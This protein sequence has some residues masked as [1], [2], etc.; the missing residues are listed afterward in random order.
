MLH[1][2]S[3]A[4]SELYLT[5][6]ELADKYLN[7][8]TGVG[9]V[10]SN[11]TYIHLWKFR[12]TRINTRVRGRT[13]LRHQYLSLDETVCLSLV[14]IPCQPD[15]GIGTRTIYTQKRIP[16][17]YLRVYQ[18]PGPFRTKSHNISADWCRYKGSIVAQA[19]Q[20]SSYIY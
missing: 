6:M 2:F 18:Q 15:Y 7:F 5:G 16:K 1:H 11:S 3:Y 19:A 14:T 20:G 10:S 4:S 13:F 17:L 9:A 12:V 8:R